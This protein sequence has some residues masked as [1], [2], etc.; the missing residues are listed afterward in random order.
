MTRKDALRL[1]RKWLPL[2]TGNRP[3]ALAQVYAKDAFYRDPARPQG[4]KGREGLLAYFRRLLA[5]FPDWVWE[6]EEVF[7][8]RGGFVL[9]WQATIPVRG[10]VVVEHGL[11]LVLV[12]R[13]KVV[14]NEVFFDRSALLAAVSSCRGGVR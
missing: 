8:V 10:T 11:D 1:C 2:W 4:I 13:G 6:A 9:R 3:E 14:R 7:P 12:A 5:A